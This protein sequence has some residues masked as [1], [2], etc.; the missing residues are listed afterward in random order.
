MIVYAV[1]E[2]PM[3]QQKVTLRFTD[4]SMNGEKLNFKIPESEVSRMVVS[5]R[6]QEV[7]VFTKLRPLYPWGNFDFKVEINK[8][9]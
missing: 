1:N 7:I 9:S 3:R 4:L 6:E 5:G 8:D 2:D